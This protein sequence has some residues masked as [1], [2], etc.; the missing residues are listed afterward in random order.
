MNWESLWSIL[1]SWDLTEVTNE[2]TTPGGIIAHWLFWLIRLGFHLLYNQLAWTYDAVAWLVSRGQWQAWGRAAL[3]H[4]QGPR[5][6]D[7]GH[8]PGHLLGALLGAGFAAAGIDR[9]RPMGEIA[10][11]R[12]VRYGLPTPLARGAARRLPFPAGTFQ[13]VVATFPSET[14]LE[15][16]A[17]TDIRR[18]LDPKGVLVIVPMAHLIGND[19]ID[20]ALELAYHLTG[21]RG[22]ATGRIEE[23]LA[24]AGFQAVVQWIDS[25]DSRVMVVT[26]RPARR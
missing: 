25:S 22:D 3:P 7:L 18:V 19:L 26:A 5:V 10:Q 1:E 8:G 20:R 17:L 9:S 23:W 16:A 14:I 2:Q 21:Q 15:T 11:R 6:L 24:A 13:S 4:L 12:L